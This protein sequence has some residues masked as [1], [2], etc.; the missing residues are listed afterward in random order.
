MG[1]KQLQI[2]NEE[3]KQNINDL[4]E[5]INSLEKEQSYLQAKND[6]M[7][8]NSN[9]T[10]ED[11]IALKRHLKSPSKFSGDYNTRKICARSI[12]SQKERKE[13]LLGIIES[14]EK[15]N[16]E[17]VEEKNAMK[18]TV[19]DLERMHRTKS[20]ESSMNR[21]ILRAIRPSRSVNKTQ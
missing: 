19:E 9:M 16:M 12:I 5:K 7:M 3:S 1:S 13:N 21:V 20:I 11:F 15:E 2:K 18:R 14:L 6:E 17:N 8:E 10:E 4:K